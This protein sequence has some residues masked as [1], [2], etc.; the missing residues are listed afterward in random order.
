[1]QLTIRRDNK[2]ID[3][4]ISTITIT[5]TDEHLISLFRCVVCGSPVSQYE[6][7]VIKL[8]PIVEPTQDALVISRCSDCG[9]L[10]TFHT[11]LVSKPQPTKVI[12]FVD[13]LRVEN[14]FRCY[15]CRQP[16]LKY[17]LNGVY[18]MVNNAVATLPY[19]L[20]CPGY[21][22]NASYRFID[23]V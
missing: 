2:P 10:Y 16:L 23:V 4:H 15:I 12:L 17:T 6:G 3:L 22:C 19:L 7:D 13:N 18:D 9:C 1:M 20:H 21:E 14:L 8:Y 5:P 11:Q